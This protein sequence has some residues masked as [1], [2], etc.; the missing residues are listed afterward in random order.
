MSRERLYDRNDG[1]GEFIGDVGHAAWL[2]GLAPANVQVPIE[3]RAGGSKSQRR[4]GRTVAEAMGDDG[5]L[6]QARMMG[7]DVLRIHQACPF[8]DN[9]RAKP[10]L[11]PWC[12]RRAL[13][14]LYRLPY[15][16]G[17]AELP[18]N[19]SRHL[20]CAMVLVRNGFLTSENSVS[21]FVKASRM[22]YNFHFFP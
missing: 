19:P 3:T 22:V 7:W 12:P 10:S 2:L 6:R 13:F 18:L 5:C 20:C 1:C 16:D 4:C 14:S 17:H 8:V 11:Y 9:C 21:D 15:P